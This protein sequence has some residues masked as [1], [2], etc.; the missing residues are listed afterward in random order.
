ME[1]IEDYLVLAGHIF[2]KENMEE[3]QQQSLNFQLKQAGRYFKLV[4]LVVYSGDKSRIVS[5]NKISKQSIS[6]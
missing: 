4:S 5:K 1:A 2:I 6:S 3:S